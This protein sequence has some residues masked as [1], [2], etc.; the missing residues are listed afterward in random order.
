MQS[1]WNK[2]SDSLA[3]LSQYL[4]TLGPVGLFAVALLDSALIPMAGGPD[5]LLILLSAVRPAWVPLYAAAATVG[6]A[7]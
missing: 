2:I 6:S 7:A 3:S 1:L 4:V 5:A